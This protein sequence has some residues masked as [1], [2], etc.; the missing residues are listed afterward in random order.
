MIKINNIKL[1]PSSKVRFDGKN[2]LIEKE[3]KNEII[4]KLRITTDRFISFKICK[5][6][7]DARKKED[8]KKKIVNYKVIKGIKR[9]IV[10]R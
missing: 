5:Q 7:I 4:K 2:W 1:S 10:K 9:Y 6:S 8:V 3:L